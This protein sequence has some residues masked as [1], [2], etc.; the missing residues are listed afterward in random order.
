MEYLETSIVLR[1][2]K[3]DKPG[4]TLKERLPESRREFSLV[5]VRAR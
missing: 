2:W 5:L 4:V 1:H 3:E